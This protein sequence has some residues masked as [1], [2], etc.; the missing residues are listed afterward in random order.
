MRDG[1]L[2]E[3]VDTASTSEEELVKAMVGRDV[4]LKV[5]RR[6]PPGKDVALRIRNLVVP[7]RLGEKNIRPSIW[8]SMPER[9]SVSPGSTATAR[10]SLSRP[11]SGCSKKKAARSISLATIYRENPVSSGDTLAS[12][13]SLPTAAKW[14]RS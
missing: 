2:I 11:S 7:H 13:I 8:I 3:T 12:A 9:S 5:D 6:T 4:D 1:R 10:P 14:D